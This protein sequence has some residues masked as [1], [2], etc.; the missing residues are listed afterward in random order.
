VTCTAI[1]LPVLAQEPPALEL[2]LEEAVRRALDNNLDI[3]VER[4]GPEASELAVEQALGAYDPALTATLSNTSRTD[5]ATNV[6]AG[7]AEVDTDVRVWN[8]GLGQYLPSGATARLTLNNNRTGTNNIY[9]DYNPSFT[10]SATLSVTQPLLRGFRIDSSRYQI[11]VARRNR[12]I[13]DLQFRATVT[14]TLANVK[15]LY[16]E[17]LAARDN[18]EVQRKSLALAKKLLEENRIRVRVGT[19]A[20]LDIVAAES[21]VA[22]REE[23]VIVADALLAQAEDAVKAAIFPA[24][25]A[26]MWATRIV[27]TERL[28]A[29]PVVV[30][31]S[32]AVTRALAQRTDIEAARKDLEK[33]TLTVGLTRNQAL[34]GVDLSFSYGATG[35]G[36]TFVER[37]RVPGSLVPGPILRTVPGGYADALGDALGLRFP[38]WSMAVNLTYPI[39]NRAGRANRARARLAREQAE[40]ALA[41]LEMNIASEVRAAG[42]AVETNLKR[43]ESTRAARTL[44]AQRLDAEEK[45]FAAG[46]STNFFVTQAQRDLELAAVNELRA[47][48]DYRKS[49]VEFERVQEA[50]FSSSGSSITVAAR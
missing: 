21:E 20:P 15:T 25:D 33:A 43:V 31:T 34:P 13:S 30:D 24:N 5:E 26:A 40:T 39:L 8:L 16:Y 36:G 22:S 7:A 17:L 12:E 49:L 50:G 6:F 35:V 38:T 10:S 18:I 44:Q 14:A 2:S 28:V 29:D 4:Y 46:M 23:G 48:V 37:E 27:P 45:K 11:Q 1:A 32:G 3:R 19:M 41:R 9:E 42:R 47:I